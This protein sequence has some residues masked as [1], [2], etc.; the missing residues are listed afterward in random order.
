MGLAGDVLFAI[1]TSGNSKNVLRV[2]ET[3]KTRSMHV[4]GFTGQSG[5]AMAQQCDIC[6]KEQSSET[7]KIQKGHEFLGHLICG[8]IELE[9]FRQ[10]R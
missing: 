9:L 7:P 5:G 10:G 1:S 6:F 8:L 3:A 2:I 4:I